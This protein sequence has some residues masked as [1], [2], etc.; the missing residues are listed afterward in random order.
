M[1]GAFR[2]INTASKQLQNKFPACKQGRSWLAQTYQ[3]ALS[4]EDCKRVNGQEGDAK[5]S[6]SRPK[7]Y[8]FF[9][10]GHVLLDHTAQLHANEMDLL[11]TFHIPPNTKGELDFQT[12]R[13]L[14]EEVCKRVKCVESPG[15]S[16]LNTV[17]ILTHLGENALFIGSIG[18]DEA[19]Q[20]L[21]KCFKE[22]NIEARLF[23]YKNIPTGECVSII[24]MD[25][26]DEV[27]YANIGA[28]DQINMDQMIQVEQ[29][30]HFLRPPE[31]KQI[32]YIE[33]FML[34]QCEEICT[35][36]V[37]NYV[38]GRR[39]LAINLSAEY[40]VRKHFDII[41]ELICAAYFIFGNFKEFS[42][43]ADKMG[44]GADLDKALKTIFEMTCGPR[45]IIITMDRE[46]VVLVANVEYESDNA[47]EVFYRRCNAVPVENVVDSTGAG[48]S[49]VAGFLH[50]FLNKYKLLDCVIVGSAVAAKVVTTIG[51]NLPKDFNVS[52]IT[53]KM[54]KN[55]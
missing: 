38:R 32:I 10:I 14:K 6:K 35:R 4:S 18:D 19:G 21:Q 7:Q 20:K 46:G 5:I 48:D 9:S 39:W 43:L 41:M 2:F 45:I 40:V 36:L 52:T 23:T 3:R 33:G 8:K 26:H 49:F 42:A 27:L 15:G 55:K 34:S 25:T 44:F 24:N 29:E 12:L 37:K 51:C 17:R 13:K 16:A 31:R 11:R 53:N 1:T 30:L 54:T 22:Q 50:A 47:G 28:S